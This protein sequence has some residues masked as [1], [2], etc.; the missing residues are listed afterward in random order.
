MKCSG[1]S[2]IL[3]GLV[4]DTVLHELVHAFPIFVYYHELIRGVSRNTRYTSFPF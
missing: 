4:H 3:H 2:E 1:D